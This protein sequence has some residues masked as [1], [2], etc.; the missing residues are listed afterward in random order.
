MSGD[1]GLDVKSQE[2]RANL[3]RVLTVAALLSLVAATSTSAAGPRVRRVDHQGGGP[4]LSIAGAVVTCS[5]HAG[6]TVWWIVSR[7]GGPAGIYS[8]RGGVSV[9]PGANPHIY[10][11][12]D[13]FGTLPPP[14]QLFIALHECAHF[15]L[16]PQPNADVFALELAADCWAVRTAVA[17]GWLASGDLDFVSRRLVA[18]AAA[19][20]GHGAS[21]VHGENIPKCLS[22]R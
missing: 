1:A 3:V 5:T 18:N 22:G 19:Q 9:V 8:S 15:H 20:W 16:P 11:N 2:V 17:T 6:G 10:L 7:S 14:V 4:S 21:A 12:A 13:V